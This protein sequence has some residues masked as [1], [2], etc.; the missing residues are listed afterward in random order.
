[1]GELI[2][3]KVKKIM[4]KEVQSIDESENVDKALEKMNFFRISC[5]VVL[6]KGSPIGILTERDLINRV[7]LKNKVPKKTKVKDVMSSPIVTKSPDF[8]T[9]KLVKIMNE[10]MIRHVPIVS[11]DKLVG[12]ITQTDIV[13]LQASLNKWFVI[14]HIL[15]II[16]VVIGIFVFFWR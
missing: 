5:I 8:S 1:M 2:F 7:L 14:Q 4:Q 16:V 3:Q 11:E 6:R 13:K 9:S 12:I 10:H 15:F